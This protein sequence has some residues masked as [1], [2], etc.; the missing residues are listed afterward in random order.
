MPSTEHSFQIYAATD[1]IGSTS[2][3][4]KYRYEWLLI[5]PLADDF[6]EPCFAV[7][8]AA[9]G[10]SPHLVRLE[11]RRHD[12]NGRFCKAGSPDQSIIVAPFG[13]YFPRND[14]GAGITLLGRLVDQSRPSIVSLSQAQ[15]WKG[16]A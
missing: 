7:I 2:A 16:A 12:G 15:S 13:L 10:G 3:G 8:A 11:P 14:I 6:A 9:P 5:E 4:N 1:V